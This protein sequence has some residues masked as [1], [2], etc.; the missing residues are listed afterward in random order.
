MSFATSSG[1]AAALSG[2]SA[3]PSKQRG[4][5]S[6]R[7]VA[8]S[9]ASGVGAGDDDEG[10]AAGAPAS[11]A[12]APAADAAAVAKAQRLAVRMAAVEAYIAE[13]RGNLR[14]SRFSD[15]HS[16]SQVLLLTDDEVWD[17]MAVHWAKPG[18][19]PNIEQ[20]AATWEGKD[21]TACVVR[22]GLPLLA[23]NA[24]KQMRA[25]VSEAVRAHA[26]QHPDL[27]AADDGADSDVDA[28]AAPDVSASVDAQLR[29]SLPRA[30]A[31][32]GHVA[33]PSPV[34]GRRSPRDNL[35]SR[36]AGRCCC[37]CVECIRSA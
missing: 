37:C 24:T 9:A 1:A 11:L 31:A 27:F 28:A 2:A 13:Q 10:A 17:D 3:L 19:S 16:S 18:A 21:L 34:A 23:A 26:K 12:A 7:S 35:S 14:G 15:Q 29:V 6:S 20:I 4:G 5:A 32:A 36:S 8:L 33:P 25:S 30:S 22:L